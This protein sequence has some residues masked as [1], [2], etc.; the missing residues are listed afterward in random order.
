MRTILVMTPYD[1]ETII[2]FMDDLK[3]E[4]KELP[5]E[6]QSPG[7]LAEIIYQNMDEK[8]P[9]S[10][11]TCFL[12]GIDAYRNMAKQDDVFIT[13]APLRFMVGTAPKE[14][15]FDEVWLYRENVTTTHEEVLAYY[16]SKAKQKET[17]LSAYLNIYN[18]EE[19]TRKFNTFKGLIGAISRELGKEMIGYGDI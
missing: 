8:N 7:L 14:I 12:A 18:A 1:R 11:F 6:V 3:N 4:I 5:I 9:Y 19:A 17:D 13:T 10:F 2:R 16:E 15:D